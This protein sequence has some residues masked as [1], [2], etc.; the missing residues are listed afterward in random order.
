MVTDNGLQFAAR[1]FPDIC[2]SNGIKYSFTPLYHPASIGATEQA[3]Q[4]VKQAMKK[5]GPTPMLREDFQTFGSLQKYLLCYNRTM[6][7]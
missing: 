2:K 7:G 3:V 6:A 4:V 5:M 1:T